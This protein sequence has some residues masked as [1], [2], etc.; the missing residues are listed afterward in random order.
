MNSLS[1]LDLGGRD[2]IKQDL[3][4]SLKLAHRSSARAKWAWWTEDIGCIL[5]CLG[6]S[7]GKLSLM[8]V[9]KFDLVDGLALTEDDD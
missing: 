8:M 2:S 1:G 9:V 4:Y 5:Y 7:S 3:T 6:L